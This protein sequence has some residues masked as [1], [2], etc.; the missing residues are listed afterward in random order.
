MKHLA[1]HNMFKDDVIFAG[2]PFEIPVHNPATGNAVTAT[3]LGLHQ[4][5][6]NKPTS[7]VIETLNQPSKEFDVLITGPQDSA[8]PIKCYQQKDGNLLAEY[9]P[10]TPGTYKIE[11]LCAMKNVKGSP[12]HC[13][14][15]DASKVIIDYR[16]TVT[17]VGEPCTFKCKYAVV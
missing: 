3:G 17:A 9:T 6:V 2:A 13:T 14:A 5:R 15:Y 11:V 12:F 10:H 7:F 16:K 8:V 4:A 1:E